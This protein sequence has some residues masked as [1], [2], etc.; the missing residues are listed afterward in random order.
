[1]TIQSTTT[2][3]EVDFT[4]LLAYALL[5]LFRGG[6]ACISSA[7]VTAGNKIENY[8]AFAYIL[9]PFIKFYRSRLL[10]RNLRLCAASPLSSY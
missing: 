4:N 9:V 1:M 10:V 2:E 6:W 8:V 5:Y 3:P 7:L